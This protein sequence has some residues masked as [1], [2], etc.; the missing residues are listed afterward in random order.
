MRPS[1]FIVPFFAALFLAVGGGFGL[2]RVTRPAV[3]MSPELSTPVLVME[4]ISPENQSKPLYFNFA[5][6]PWLKEHWQ[7]WG[8]AFGSPLPLIEETAL[9][10]EAAAASPE[11]WRILDRKWRFGAV[12]L[13]GDPASFRPL[14]EHLR[15]SPDW[16]LTQLGPY[17][18]LFERSP[19]QAWKTTD[20]EPVLAAFQTHSPEEQ[21]TARIQ[22]AHRLVFLEEMDAARKLLEEVL[23]VN[24]KSA[25]AWA[26]LASLDGMLGQW[27]KALQQSKKALACDPANRLARYVIINAD[28][29]LG[30]FDDALNVSRGLYGVASGEPDILFLHAR[31]THAAHAYQEEVEVLQRI[32]GL[33]QGRSQPVGVWQVFLGQAFASTGAGEL[34][35]EQFRL[36]LQDETLKEGDR[37]FAEKALERIEASVDVFSKPSSLP[38]SSLLDVPP[39]PP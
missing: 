8:G 25:P 13:A 24:A 5:A 37:A 9:Q 36:A 14:L 39:Y 16:T 6:V 21:R 1:Y 33:L 28:Y 32:I 30:R 12:L 38:K 7:K 35:A 22:I 29:A 26:E 34:A 18:L 4:R 31:V 23:K 11:A 17:S 20:I 3:Q 2:W 15:Q 27:T 19:A 10:F